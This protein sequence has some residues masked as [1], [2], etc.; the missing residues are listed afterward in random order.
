MSAILKDAFLRRL[1]SK[2]KI[3]TII[4]Y[5]HYRKTTKQFCIDGKTYPYLFHSYNNMG[6]TERSVEI[7]IIYHYL[8]IN[9]P[10]RVLEIGNV[11]NYYESY[12]S[13]VFSSKTV[14]DKLEKNYN[15]ITSDIAQYESDQK[16]DFVFSI[17]T[18]EHMDS[19]LGRNPEY[20]KGSAKLCSI[21]ADNIVHCYENLLSTN[22]L[23]L[24]TAPLGYTPEWDIT[25]KSECL[26]KMSFKKIRRRI[27]KKINEQEWI[28]LD[29]FD[30]KNDDMRCD[31]PYP[32]VNYVSVFEI[33]K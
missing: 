31:F 2:I 16:F 14:V 25:F 29:Q 9:K 21:A 20:N 22:G 6:I 19:D 7:P 26:D 11:T 30:L 33:S 15:I 23:M 24:I 12:F 17:S 8:N 13:N 5:L 27:F 18:F 28:E 1:F 32:N 4:T 10:K 3:E